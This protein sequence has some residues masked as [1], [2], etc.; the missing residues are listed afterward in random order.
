MYQSELNLNED[1]EEQL[2]DSRKSKA[3]QLLIYSAAI[4]AD[5][6]GIDEIQAGIRS[7]RNTKDG[8]LHLTVAKKKNISQVEIDKML[9]WL[10][11]K[12]SSLK[13]EGRVLSHNSDAKYCEYCV[14]L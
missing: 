7:G 5:T 13:E 11:N 9:N 10:L 2:D 14:S 8:L 12:I 6:K 3:L 1:F 4:L